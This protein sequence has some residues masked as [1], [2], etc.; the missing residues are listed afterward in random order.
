MFMWS[1]RASESPGVIGPTSRRTRPRLSRRR[2]RST[3][4]SGSSATSF[5][6]FTVRVYAGRGHWYL[7]AICE[8]TGEPH[9]PEHERAR[10]RLD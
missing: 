5:T 6:A 4:N 10:E 3:G 7:T 2:V 8:H 9:E 1:A